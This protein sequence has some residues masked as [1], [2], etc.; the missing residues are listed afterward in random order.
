[1]EN[2]ENQK[3]TY[4]RIDLM[5]LIREHTL[6][7]PVIAPV[8]DNWIRNE[9]DREGLSGTPKGI[10]FSL[11]K[12]AALYFDAGYPGESLRTLSK[13]EE[14]AKAKDIG[15]LSLADTKITVDSYGSIKSPKG[16][17]DYFH[18]LSKD[19]QEAI[20]QHLDYENL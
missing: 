11:I 7:D 3:N 12:E 2:F 4:S 5:K 20:K 16:L 17:L 9:C 6:E 15:T 19:L 14:Y 18:E 13:A 10:V 1:M 8:V